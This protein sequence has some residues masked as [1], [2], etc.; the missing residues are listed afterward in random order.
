MKRFPEQ[1]R[2][3]HGAVRQGGVEV[4]DLTLGFFHLPGQRTALLRVTAGKSAALLLHFAKQESQPLGDEQVPGK[5]A[6][7]KPVQLAFGNGDRGLAGVSAFQAMARTGVIAVTPALAGAQNKRSAAG[8]A[9]GNPGQKHV[10]VADARSRHG[11]TALDQA[12]LNVGE[13]LRIDDDGN[14]HRDPFGF[15]PFLASAAVRAVVV[16]RAG[17]GV[18]GQNGVD[19]ADVEGLASAVLEPMTVEP[20]GNLLDAHRPLPA[21]PIPEQAE[22]GPDDLGSPGIDLQALLDPLTASLDGNGAIAE[23]RQRPIPEP[24]LGIL[25]HGPGDML[26]GLG[27]GV[28]VGRRKHGLG[29]IGGGTLAKAL[30]HGE[31]RDS[32]L[33]ELA[34]PEGVSGHVAEE[35]RLTVEQH[36]IVRRGIDA[37]RIHHAL[38]LGALVV[39]GAGSGIDILAHDMPAALL[40]EPPRLRQLVRYRDIVLG[41]ARGGHARIDGNPLAH[42]A[43]ASLSLAQTIESSSWAMTSTSIVCTGRCCGNSSATRNG[44]RRFP[45]SFAGTRRR[46]ERFSSALMRPAFR[47][48]RRSLS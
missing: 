46:G 7:D 11:R 10:A 8:L 42:D 26:G 13:L 25:Q 16:E 35:A 22:H 39:A 15:G 4:L 44:L 33:Q 43:P 47:R 19:F 24:L 6:K 29:K 9:A 20:G 34:F 28:L 2:V 14:L 12:P 18:P 17:V 45:L 27:A 41:L 36:D 37:G 3:G 23:G 40:A 48:N 21:I 5:R 30:G 31:E 1:G 38:E 32:M